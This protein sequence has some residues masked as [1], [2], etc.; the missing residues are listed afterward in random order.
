MY[1]SNW[2]LRAHVPP[3]PASVVVNMHLHDQPGEHG[4]EFS[5]QITKP[6][7]FLT[8]MASPPSKSTLLPESIMSFLKHNAVDI[9]YHRKQLQHPLSTPCGYHCVFF[10]HHCNNGLPFEELL[11]LYSNDLVQNDRMMMPF[12][13]YEYGA[14]PVTRATEKMFQKTQACMSC[15]DFHKCIL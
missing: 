5:W 8:R 3:R 12:V 1:P 15:N 11:K 14:F 9:A 7:S 6:Q 2:L 4:L 13:K 10:L